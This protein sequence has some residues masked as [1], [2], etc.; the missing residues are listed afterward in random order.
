MLVME[1]GGQE[2]RT[3]DNVDVWI[4]RHAGDGEG[5]ICEAAR[6]SCNAYCAFGVL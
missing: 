2:R 6:A 4:T 3:H 1:E 5:A